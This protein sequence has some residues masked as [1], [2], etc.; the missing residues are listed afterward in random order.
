LQGAEARQTEHQA[1]AIDISPDGTRDGTSVAGDL[2]S[3]VAL[4]GKARFRAVLKIDV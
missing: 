4:S 3:R 2:C 1:A